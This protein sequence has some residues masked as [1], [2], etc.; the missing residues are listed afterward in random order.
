MLRPLVNGGHT[1]TE[2]NTALT[3]HYP[4][5]PGQSFGKKP[6][7]Q[8]PSGKRRNGSYKS[9]LGDEQEENGVCSGVD[10]RR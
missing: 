2:R 1:K 5:A 6:D 3:Q 10:G 4:A 7:P 9:G 8:N